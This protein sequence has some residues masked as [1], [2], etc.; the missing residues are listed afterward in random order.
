M[1]AKAFIGILPKLS[2]EE[3]LEITSIYSISGLN[4]SSLITSPQMR[5]P[6][7]TSSYVSICGGGRDIKAG[8]I[9]LAHKGVLLLDEFPEF[10]RRVI[11]SLRQP[12]E[13]KKI[14]I[15]RASFKIE[16][17]ADFILFTTLNPCPCGFKNSN[18]KQCICSA[19]QIDRYNQ[20]LTGPIIDRIDIW[21]KVSHINH[22]KLLSKNKKEESHKYKSLI[23]TTREAQIK[24]SRK[25]NNSL[26][27]K[28]IKE[29][30]INDEIKNLLNTASEKIKLSPRGYYKTLKVAR[31]IADIENSN[32]IKKGHIL[33]ALQY[34]K[35]D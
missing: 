16:L 13:D 33:E 21:I 11:D 25:L 3:Q 35:K 10:E 29:W 19:S 34:R 26:T 31:T 1:L 28:E 24:R 12:L 7:H 15:S 2:E 4:K 22:K 20:K 18:I 27:T 17:P 14:S 9:T 23:S 5:S 8:E 6:H 30:K 32:E